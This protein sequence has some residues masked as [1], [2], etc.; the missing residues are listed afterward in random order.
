MPN[1]ISTLQKTE[2]IID[3]FISENVSGYGRVATIYI[4]GKNW[5]ITGDIHA[6]QSWLIN[7]TPRT[8]NGRKQVYSWLP[9]MTTYDNIPIDEFLEYSKGFDELVRKQEEIE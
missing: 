9:G 3:V 5:A 1:F 8:K 2:M 4:P 7:H 6:I